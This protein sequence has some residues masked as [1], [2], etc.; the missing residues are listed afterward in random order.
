MRGGNAANPRQAW[1]DRNPLAVW[2]VYS[3]AIAPAGATV[4][5]SYTVPVVRKAYLEGGQA[6]VL[7]QTVAAPVDIAQAFVRYTPSGGSGGPL[8]QANLLNNAVGALD[9]QN[10]SSSVLGFAGDLFEGVTV[11]ASTGG[12]MVVRITAKFTEFDA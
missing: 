1:Y 10:I 8:A 3:A 4:R 6:S 5:W 12:T 11:D 7:R 9:T 2:K